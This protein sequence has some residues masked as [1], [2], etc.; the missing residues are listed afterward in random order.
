MSTIAQRFGARADLYKRNRA[1]WQIISAEVFVEQAMQ[2][3]EEKIED[4][5]LI[6]F[7]CNENPE[8][9]DCVEEILQ[10]EEYGFSTSRTTPPGNLV[11]YW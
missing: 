9:L 6:L 4:R 1:E 5:E 10:G 7:L 8:V 11:I 3:V 2:Q